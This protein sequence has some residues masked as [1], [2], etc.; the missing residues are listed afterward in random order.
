M[1]ER[2]LTAK[3]M[4][5]IG[6]QNA[7]RDRSQRTSA[8]EIRTASNPSSV[9]PP[10]EDID[11]DWEVPDSERPE[12]WLASPDALRSVPPPADLVDI[13]RVLTIE[14]ERE[15]D[16]AAAETAQRVSE[17]RST[18]YSKPSAGP[19]EEAARTAEAEWERDEAA[20]DDDEAEWE[21][22]EAATDDDEAEWERDE[23]ATDDDEDEW[24]RDEATTDDDE[25]EWERDEAATDEVDK[26]EE[27]EREEAATDEVDEEPERDHVATDEVDEEPEQDEAAT[28]EVEDERDESEAPVAAA[29]PARPIRRWWP[30]TR[31]IAA[32]VAGAALVVAVVANVRQSAEVPLRVIEA[33]KP[34]SLAAAAAAATTVHTVVVRARPEEAEILMGNRVIGK[35]AATVEVKPR[36]HLELLVRSEGYASRTVSVDESASTV[37][38][39]LAPE[40][41]EAAA[42]PEAPAKLRAKKAAKRARA[43]KPAAKRASATW[44][45]RTDR[46]NP[47][48][49]PIDR[50]N[51]Y[52]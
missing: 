6:D 9:P 3:S 43:K 41:S 4:E 47:Y 33:G 25:D 50:F 18:P 42:K 26:G 22:D 15:S 38:V 2:Q 28:D 14:A 32:G 44:R 19:A 34:V 8:W 23:A 12:T 52:D 36:Q 1:A 27:L 37:L 13:A 45:S 16:S 48:A 17:Y 30:R 11:S 24:E 21:R 46:Y 39:D 49:A 40:P 51:P 35:G 7:R 5:G 31:W 29:E 20:T 10:T